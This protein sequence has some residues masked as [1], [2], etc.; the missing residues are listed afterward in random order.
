MRKIQFRGRRKNDG[1][2]CYGD[3]IRCGVR[4][5]I[6]DRVEDYYTEVEFETV[7]QFTGHTDKNGKKIFEGDIIKYE[8]PGCSVKYGT[9]NF[10]E[11]AINSD[12]PPLNIGF[13]ISWLNNPFVR[14][15]LGFWLEQREIVIAGNIQDNLE[16]I[17]ENTK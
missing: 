16:L 15:D 14:Q 7:G 4:T 9:I 12:N 5:Y 10:G 13:Y 6:R 2:W 17:K 1:K 8:T 3:Y 11:Y